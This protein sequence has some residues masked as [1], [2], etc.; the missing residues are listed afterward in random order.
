MLEMKHTDVFNL[1]L[2]AF[3]K[4]GG[5]MEGWKDILRGYVHDKVNIENFNCRVK[6]YA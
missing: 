4:T 1:F 6:V 5:T 3:T 2:N